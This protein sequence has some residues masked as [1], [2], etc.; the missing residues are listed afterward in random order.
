MVNINKK[1][2]VSKKKI[3]KIVENN[4][5]AKV[6]KDE[7]QSDYKNK[8]NE[9]QENAKYKISQRAQDLEDE[10]FKTEQSRNIMIEQEN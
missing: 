9:F 6:R 1:T 4:K 8:L 2:T 10:Q 7:A 5:I 3:N